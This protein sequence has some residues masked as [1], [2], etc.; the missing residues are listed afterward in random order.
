[1]RPKK[2]RSGA[3]SGIEK[4]EQSATSTRTPSSAGPAPSAAAAAAA[5]ATQA[6]SSRRTASGSGSR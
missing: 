5:R 2:P 6:I 3:V 4:L 1:M